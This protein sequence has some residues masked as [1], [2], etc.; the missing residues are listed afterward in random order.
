MAIVTTSVVDLVVVRF[1]WEAVGLA[2]KH[3]VRSWLGRK[4]AGATVAGEPIAR[5]L[6]GV[7]LTVFIWRGK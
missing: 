5:A 6:A 7:A 4:L 3:P 2:F 1:D